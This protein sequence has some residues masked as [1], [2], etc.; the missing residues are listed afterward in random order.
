M[1]ESTRPPG[2]LRF[3]PPI[4]LPLPPH[5]HVV[6]SLDFETQLPA[7]G[8]LEWADTGV[9]LQELSAEG[10]RIHNMRVSF[11]GRCVVALNALGWVSFACWRYR[12]SQK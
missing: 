9:S 7:V 10:A 4:S 1:Y 12:R 8:Q 5:S 11:Y 2:M 3:L 6:H